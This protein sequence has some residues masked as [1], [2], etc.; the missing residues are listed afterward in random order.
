MNFRGNLY[1]RTPRFSPVFGVD[2][3]EFEDDDPALRP[4]LLLF[5]Y[6]ADRGIFQS[7]RFG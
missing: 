1:H 2:C 6:R 3:V 7:R 5:G 4:D